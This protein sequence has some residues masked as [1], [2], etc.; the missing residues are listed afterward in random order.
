MAT[1]S[2]KIHNKTYNLSC[3]EGGQDQLIALASV[4]NEKVELLSK[5]MVGVSEDR[6][7]L[8]AAIIL[9]DEKEDAE[10]ARREESIRLKSEMI[11]L[12]A[13]VEEMKVAQKI[14]S[15][16]PDLP[17]LEE[18][19]SIDRELSKAV[20]QINALA[21]KLESQDDFPV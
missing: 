6:L 18:I 8:M 14:T 7:I 5:Q 20:E 10:N 3:K 2:V 12:K 19:K 4:V 17:T 13:A 15:I 1:L 21:R 9:A 11:E 16:S